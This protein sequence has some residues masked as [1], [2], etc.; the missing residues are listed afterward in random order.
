VLYILEYFGVGYSRHETLPIRKIKVFRFADKAVALS[1]V[2]RDYWLAVGS[3]AVYIP[4]PLDKKA[5]SVKKSSLDNHNIL[6][7]GRLSKQKGHL[8][9][10][11]I[12]AKVVKAIPDAQMIF[13][14]NF[15]TNSDEQEFYKKI[16]VDDY[17]KSIINKL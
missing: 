2:Q 9:A 10:L 6:W 11:E 4:N 12:L 15:F 14:G 1:R 16:I 5:L 17:Q 13:A 7:V 8:D 3:N